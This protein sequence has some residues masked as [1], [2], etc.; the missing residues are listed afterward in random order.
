MKKKANVIIKN[1]IEELKELLKEEIKKDNESTYIEKDETKVI[2]NINNKTLIRNNSGLYMKYIFD[3][4][5]STIG[6][7][8]VK[9]LNKTIKVKIKTKS[10]SIEKNNIKINYELEDEDYIYIIDME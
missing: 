6:I 2:F 1:K 7:I 4:T 8:I 9:D 3:D 5:K 10:I